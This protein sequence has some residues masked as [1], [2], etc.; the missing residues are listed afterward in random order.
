MTAARRRRPRSGT[1]VGA[2]HELPT[3]DQSRENVHRA[4][5]FLATEQR[6]ADPEMVSLGGRSVQAP[7][8][9]YLAPDG[10][11]PVGEAAERRAETDPDRVRVLDDTHAAPGHVPA[12]PTRQARARRRARLATT[13]TARTDA[14]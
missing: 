6:H 13:Q 4:A 2:T 12:E 8:V 9:L 3:R 10:A 5:V 7:S 11:V 14:R 1:G